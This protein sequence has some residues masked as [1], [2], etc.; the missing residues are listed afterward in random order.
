MRK[1]QTV[2]ILVN[3]NT[4]N[5]L[6]ECMRSIYRSQNSNNIFLVVFDNDSKERIYENDFKAYKN[7][8][9]IKSNKNIGFGNANNFSFQWAK[10]NLIFDYFFLLNSDTIIKKNSIV[11]LI[12]NYPEGNNVIAVSPKILTYEKPEK[13]WLAPAHFNFFKFAPNIQDFG[14]INRNYKNCYVDFISGCA[15]FFKYENFKSEIIFDKFFFMYD[16]DFE[17]CFRAKINHKKLYFIN[18]SVIFH[19]CQSSQVSSKYLN[20]FSPLNESNIFLINTI[21]NRFYF[22]N[23]HFNGF[24]MIFQKLKLIIYFKLIAIRYLINGSFKNFKILL[25]NLILE[26]I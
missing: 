5:D 20:Q 6:L 15:M 24:Y 9:L 17:F 21:K 10:K 23:K 19:K 13:V 7:I 12:N 25:K 3:Y 8:K 14:K 26:L 1:F 2:I 4:K 22:I 11:N 18:T 16:E